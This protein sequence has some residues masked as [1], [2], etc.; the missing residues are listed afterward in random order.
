[1]DVVIAQAARRELTHEAMLQNMLAQYARKEYEDEIY[2]QAE[3]LNQNET[4][5]RKAKRAKV[6]TTSCEGG[7]GGHAAKI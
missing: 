7:D 3:R 6:S 4:Q 2:A 5:G 1:M